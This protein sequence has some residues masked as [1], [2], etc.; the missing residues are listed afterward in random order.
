MIPKQQSPMRFGFLNNRAI[1]MQSVRCNGNETNIL[2]CSHNAAGSSGTHEDDLAIVCNEGKFC[3][4]CLRSAKHFA[5]NFS[6]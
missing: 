3:P 2:D 6:C 5:Y 1:V 4:R